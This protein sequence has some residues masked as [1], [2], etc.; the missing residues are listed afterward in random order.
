METQSSQ[1]LSPIKLAI[2]KFEDLKEKALNFQ[3][4][5]YLDGVLAVLDGVVKYEEDYIAQLLNPTDNNQEGRWYKIYC[6]SARHS[7]FVDFYLKIK[8]EFNLY[9]GNK[10]KAVFENL[11]NEAEQIRDW[12]IDHSYTDD[13]TDGIKDIDAA[14]KSAKKAIEKF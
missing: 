8:E 12:A 5:I 4:A 2:K 3:D 7:D 11:I 1:E 14:I 6:E 10:T 13:E 9:P